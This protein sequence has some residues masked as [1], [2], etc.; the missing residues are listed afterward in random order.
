MV[1]FHEACSFFLRNE[2]KRRRRRK[3]KRLK[4]KFGNPRHRRG[5]N[6]GKGEKRREISVLNTTGHSQ[7]CL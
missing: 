3:G 1:I 7:T 4:N 5:E 6:E 2:Y